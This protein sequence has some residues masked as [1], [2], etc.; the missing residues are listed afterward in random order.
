M[1]AYGLLEIGEE[2]VN[3]ALGL[4]HTQSFQ[5]LKRLELGRTQP[6]HFS[7][8]YPWDLGPEW[9]SPENRYWYSDGVSI[10]V[11]ITA[12]ILLQ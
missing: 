5:L 8:W 7:P 4:V 10:T 1:S 11:K 9:A 2:S 3:S 12:K 6:L